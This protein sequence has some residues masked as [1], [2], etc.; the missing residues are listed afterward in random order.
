MGHNRIY[1]EEVKQ[2]ESGSEG[3]WT[4]KWKMCSPDWGNLQFLPGNK[5]FKPNVHEMD[6][7]LLRS[8][9]VCG[10]PEA[11]TKHLGSFFV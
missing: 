6:I 10:A 7:N 11:V 8:I 9:S 3:K 4:F 5:S 1:L 2:E